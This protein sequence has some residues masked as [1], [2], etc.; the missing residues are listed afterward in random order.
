MSWISP[1]LIDFTT[2]V[3]NQGVAESSL[4]PDSQYLVWAYNQALPV[5][6]LPGLNSSGLLYTLAVYNLGMHI[7]L[8]LA[9]DLNFP[10]D[11]NIAPPDI[12]GRQ[13]TAS[14]VVNSTGNIISFKTIDSGQNYTSIPPMSIS[15][16]LSGGVQATG[17]TI[18]EN[19]EVSGYV[20]TNPGTQ[21]PISNFWSSLRLRYKYDS[22]IT[23]FVQSTSDQGTST[24]L[25]VPR[26]FDKLNISSLRKTG[27]P[28][29][30]QYLEYAE[31]YGMDPCVV[32]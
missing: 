16:P 6:R 32:V 12:L 10:V 28:W 7:L 17:T 13:A 18:I 5:V 31:S 20:L 11:V 23:G 30:L 15:P 24:S 25:L 26:I 1:N 14:A 3:Y 22:F 19:G 27:T 9:Q 29:G 8:G 4:P 2:F 21:Y